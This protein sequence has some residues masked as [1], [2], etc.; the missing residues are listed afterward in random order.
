MPPVS[1]RHILHSMGIVLTLAQIETVRAASDQD[2]TEQEVE[3]A[4][5][6]MREHGVLRR[7]LLV[8]AEA[9]ARLTAGKGEIPIGALHDAADLFR[10]FGEEYHERSLE[11]QHVFPTLIKAGGPNAALANVL[12][13]QHERGR[14]FT[15]YIS[16]ITGRGRVSPANAEPFRGALTVFVRMYEHHAA[17]ED[18]IVFPAWKAAISP[19]QYRE[20]SEQFEELEQKMFGKDGFDDAVERI[21]RIEQAFGLADLAR[22]TA[23]PPPKIAM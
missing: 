11:E 6:L 1:R 12:Q 10:T 23:P 8:Y 3:A 9:A 18:T 4:E 16:A 17:I 14:E 20:L 19:A 7:A 5:D 2:D 22:L 15:D 21:A 13:H